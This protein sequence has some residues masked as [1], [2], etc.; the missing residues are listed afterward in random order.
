MNRP[1]ALAAAAALAVLTVAHAAGIGIGIASAHDGN[2]I[3][4]VESRGPGTGSS[5]PYVIRLTW[6]NDGHPAVDS[7]VTATVI[8]ID[9]T[10]HTPVVMGPIDDDG[11]YAATIAYDSGGSWTV[12]FTA[13]TPTATIEVVEDVAEPTATTTRVESTDTTRSTAT[14]S[15][16]AASDP[17]DGGIGVG[18]V[19]AALFLGL[20]VVGCGIGFA[21]SARR[22][23]EDR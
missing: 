16:E 11:R 6:K 15:A 19:L 14:S 2:G 9:G 23:G 20:V 12:R 4:V 3:I 1:S 17:D 21:R 13:V 7:T 10:P 5:V 8:G 18:G 22:P